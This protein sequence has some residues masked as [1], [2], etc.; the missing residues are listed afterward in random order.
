MWLYTGFDIIHICIY[1]N[2]TI[3]SIE[4]YKSTTLSLLFHFSH[5]FL[6]ACDLPRLKNIISYNIYIY[7]Y[8]E[9]SK[10]I[11]FVCDEKKT[12]FR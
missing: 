1:Q 8:P 12:G 4:R 9:S 11:M 7:V 10:F 5:L 2:S 3:Y 6:V